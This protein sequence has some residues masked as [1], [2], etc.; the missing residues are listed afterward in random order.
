[1]CSSPHVP[2]LSAKSTRCS[3]ASNPVLRPDR[4]HTHTH[5]KHTNPPKAPK[6]CGAI[7]QL[8]TGSIK[9]FELGDFLLSHQWPKTSCLPCGNGKDFFF[10]PCIMQPQARTTFVSWRTTTLVLLKLT[11]VLAP[12]K[13]STPQILREVFPIS[14]P[15]FTN[16]RCT[17]PKAPTFS[18]RCW[19][20]SVGRSRA[21][22]SPVTQ[23][24]TEPQVGGGKRVLEAFFRQFVIDRH[25]FFSP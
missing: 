17:T 13:A 8:L 15:A 25:A 22:K 7:R 18:S 1:M 5:R 19:K 16:P 20:I 23:T 3:F 6:C 9:C 12:D 21:E 11:V 10:K 2:V 24:K 14:F 4:T